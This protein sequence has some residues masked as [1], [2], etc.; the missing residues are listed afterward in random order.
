VPPNDGF[1]TQVTYKGAFS[2]QDIWAEHWT[3]LDVMGFLVCDE[4]VITPPAAVLPLAVVLSIVQ[5]GA[6]V[7][8]TFASQN[9]VNYQLQS[10]TSLTTGSFTDTPDA[11]QVGNGSTLTFSVPV[12][13]SPNFYQVRA[14]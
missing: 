10:R 11:P 8:I 12:G 1:F 7:D 5:N 6:N 13:G 9:G 3:A 2:T 4:T 14:Y